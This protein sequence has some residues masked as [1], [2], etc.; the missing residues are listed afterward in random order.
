MFLVQLFPRL[1]ACK[2]ELN[3]SNIVNTIEFGFCFLSFFRYLFFFYEQLHTYDSHKHLNNLSTAPYVLFDTYTHAK[4]SYK[5]YYFIVYRCGPIIAYKRP[6]IVF[7]VI[8]MLVIVVALFT[9]CWL[10]LQTYNILQHIFP[11]INE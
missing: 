2:I 1:R 7:K 5:I 3:H 10:P 6:M 8:K 9:L 11:E 4:I